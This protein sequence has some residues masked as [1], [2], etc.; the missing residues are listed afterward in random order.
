MPDFSKPNCWKITGTNGDRSCPDLQQHGHC[1]NCPVYAAAAGRLFDRAP[2]PDYIAEQTARLARP[3]TKKEEKEAVALVFRLGAEWLALPVGFVAEIMPP[4]PVR[5]VPHRNNRHLRGLVSWR[6]DIQLC[7]SMPALLGLEK[8]TRSP[9]AP[10]RPGR[11]RFC[12]LSHRQ[13][14][15]VFT[16]DEIR[17]LSRYAANELKPVPADMAGNL[18]EWTLGIIAGDRRPAALLNAARI[19]Q[20]LERSLG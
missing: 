3:E 8:E 1:R 15:W 13:T 11:P 9:A 7:F 5:P 17:G 10:A 6:G 2:P 4:R 12:R 14:E 16:A 19:F 18:P 20:E